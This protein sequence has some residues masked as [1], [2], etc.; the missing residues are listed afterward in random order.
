MSYGTDADLDGRWLRKLPPLGSGAP[1]IPLVGASG[2]K[3]AG[4]SQSS[5]SGLGGDDGRDFIRFRPSRRYNAEASLLT[6]R[7]GSDLETLEINL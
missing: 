7:R 4:L 1:P 2:L 3:M 5:K 6:R